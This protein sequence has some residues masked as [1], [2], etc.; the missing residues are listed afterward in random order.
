MLRS[1]LW[2]LAFVAFLFTGCTV[3]T[4]GPLSDPGKAEPDESLYGHWVATEKDSDGKTSEIHFFIGKHTTKGNPASILECKGI[5]WNVDDKTVSGSDSTGY[6]TVTRIGKT[7]YLNLFEVKDAASVSLVEPGS[8]TNWA[9]NDKR[10]CTVLRYSCDGKELRVW[11]AKD[12]ESKVKKLN[13][14]GDLKVTD[15][16]VRAD[17]LVQYLKKNGGDGLFD[18]LVFTFSK[19]R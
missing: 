16:L 10:R 1:P 19:V 12:A 8:Y 17:S 6:L 15:K 13:E 9:K 4:T 11:N 2:L 5:R 7:S 3:T 14:A 18:E